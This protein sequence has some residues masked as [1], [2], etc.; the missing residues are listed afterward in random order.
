[1]ELKDNQPFKELLLFHG[2]TVILVVL[3]ASFWGSGY[4]ST[5]VW[6]PFFM[7][8][9]SFIGEKN[10]VQQTWLISLCLNMLLVLALP[11]GGLLG[12]FTGNLMRNKYKGTISIMQ[13]AL[14]IAGVV[15]VPAYWVINNNYKLSFSNSN[16]S[17]INCRTW[18]VAIAQLSLCVPLALFG[19]NL[20]AFMV[21]QFQPRFRYSGIGLGNVVRSF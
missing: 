8:E 3:V 6:L 18:I 19:G 21:S 20:P 9:N 17:E 7:T 1:M 5:F 10:I 2:K 12:D 15:I 13:L 11:I 4:Y 16:F 14:C